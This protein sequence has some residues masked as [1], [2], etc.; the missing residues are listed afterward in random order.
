MIFNYLKSAVRSLLRHRFFSFINVFGLAVAMSICMAMIMLV[1]DQVSY[2]RYNSNADRIY[3]VTTIDVDEK[4][5][6]MRDNS[7]NS[8]CSMPV[9][10]ELEH[11]AGIE[12]AV[13]LRRGFGNNWDGFENQNVN[14]PLA[15]FFA[16]AD[17][18]EFFQYELQY[19]DAATALKE[20]FTVVLTRAAANKLFK[21]E[22][23]VVQTLKV[24]DLGLYTV[25][26]ILKETNRKSHIVFEGLASMASVK[27]LEEQGKLRKIIDSWSDYWSSWVYFRVVE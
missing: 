26:G 27:S 25:T 10:P 5:N 24:G 23:P 13:R 4:G 15:G 3:R 16:D 17:V 8:A 1:A 11:Y 7:T 12:K 6:V 2:D 18:L 9:A 21:E 14:I 22:N 20:P 19:G